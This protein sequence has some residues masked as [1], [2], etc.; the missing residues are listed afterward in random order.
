MSDFET[1][2]TSE[3]RERQLAA[4]LE[5]LIDSDIAAR[6]KLEDLIAKHPQLSNEL[7]QLWGTVMIVDALAD[8]EHSTLSASTPE[9]LLSESQPPTDLGDFELLEEIGRGGMGIVYRARQQT[10]QREVA[11]KLI[12]RG[13]Q[14]SS[15]EQ[16][17]FQTEIKSAAMLEHPH[18]VP[19]YDVG[20][21]DGWQ[22][23]AMKLIHG[24]T[25]EARMARGPMPGLEAAQLVEKIARAIQFAH[26]RGVIH[27]DLKPAN[28]LLDASGEPHIS[29]FGL[30]KQ[31]SGKASLTQ[32]GAILGTPAY[33][34]PEQ[35]A[36]GRGEIGPAS[37]VYSLGAILYALLT[38]RA[39]FQGTS[40]VDTV[41]MVL[42][43]DPLLP[44]LLNPRMSRDLEMI[45]LRCLQKP[46]DLRYKS[47]K[48][49]ADDLAAYQA[50]E[51][52]SARSGYISDVL[53]RVFRE[54]HHA[55]VLE[56]WGVLWMWHAVL[57]LVLCA[58]TNW[59]SLLGDTIPRMNTVG[60]YLLLWGGGLAIWAPTFWALRHRAG[61]VT[62]VERQ[63]A[64]AWGASIAAVVLL[65]VV[66]SLLGLPVLTLSPVL[67]LISG[68]V[69][70]V[71]AGILAGSFYIHAIAL[72]TTSVIMAW[73]QNAGWPYGISLF[74]VVSA[75]TFFFPG[76]KYYRQSKLA[77][78]NS[79][80]E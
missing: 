22:Y 37:D 44:R 21:V 32:S 77:E 61:P 79:K 50:G 76:W 43:Q 27:R 30:A 71:K 68:M 64:H 26:D 56:N 5:Q 6:P 65:F 10:L 70:V 11:V 67:G 1:V 31:L 55:T 78:T 45:V 74:G 28:I 39:P 80:A 3:Q 57:L 4:I 19:I 48:R 58:V 47:A 49:L 60:P 35:A 13:A 23:F 66:E 33:M 7:R 52:I 25:L 12:L 46:S 40:P 34:A 24:E 42:E 2:S 15:S 20:S 36:G 41:L 53:A 38:G 29:D 14:A 73:L 54:T 8:R 72:M 63:I 62:A 18:I 9:A 17:R 16:A 69:F 75:A 59:F 51:P